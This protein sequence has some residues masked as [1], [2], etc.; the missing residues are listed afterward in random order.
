MGVYHKGK[1]YTIKEFLEILD[2]KEKAI[3][4]QKYNKFQEDLAEH[5][6]NSDKYKPIHIPD[7]H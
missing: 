4:I 2:D 7:D 6:R 3:F 5:I 1:L